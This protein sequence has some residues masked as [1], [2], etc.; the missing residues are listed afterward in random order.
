M[1]AGIKRVGVIGLG[2]MG[3]PI[4]R[5]LRGA[6]FEVVG[7]DLA[8]PAVHGAR[9]AA[10]EVVD[11]P[12]AVARASEL[13]L[14]AVGFDAE[15]EQVV[16]AA[17]GLLAGAAGGTRIAVCATVAP[18]FMRSLP[19]RAARDDVVF[20]DAP[21]CR[22]EA[23]AERADLLLMG[24]GPAVHFDACRPAFEAFC[25]AIHYLGEL[26]AGQVGKLV[27][28]LILWACTV[29][30]D[31]G[32]RLAGALGVDEERLRAALLQSSAANWSLEIWREHRAMPWAEKDM[33]QVLAEAD[34]ARLSLPL[35]GV[36]REAIKALKIA[37][38]LGMPREASS[39]ARPARDG[40]E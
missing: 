23:A 25:G 12:A 8:A 35:C 26:G 21:L 9:A 40:D 5:H 2:R 22:G 16:T 39:R 4:A 33:T 32:L 7:F 27:N 37:R 24:G 11:S 36:T 28:N 10:I 19:G 30:N 14:V 31:E 18:S 1:S 13:V 38:G 29:A 6:G 15:V 20:L 17:D 34:V 3:L